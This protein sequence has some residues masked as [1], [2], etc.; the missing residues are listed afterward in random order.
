MNLDKFNDNSLIDC[1]NVFI[2]DKNIRD[3]YLIQ[4]FVPDTKDIEE[5]I[6]FVQN[7]FPNINLF[8]NNNYFYLSKKELSLK[9]VDTEDK[10]GSLLR[11]DCPTRFE[12]I[13]RWVNYVFSNN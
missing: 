10:I 7:I 11:F 3:A 1:I 9:N 4:S 8:R 6:K 12:D 13:D 5:R 2:V